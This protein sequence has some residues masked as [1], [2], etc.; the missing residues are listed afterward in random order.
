MIVFSYND[1]PFEQLTD[2]FAGFLQLAA[3]DRAAGHYDPKAVRQRL[4]LMGDAKVCVPM[5]VDLADRR[6][7][8]TDLNTGADGGFH[9]VRR[10]HAEV[11]G[12]CRDVLAHFAEGRRATLWDLA[13]AVAA[14]GSDEVLV[15]ERD[16]GGV[17]AWRR[18]GGEAVA[19]FAARLRDRRAPDAREGRPLTERL[20]G[21]RAFVALVDGDVPA[22]E[23]MSGTA[24]R[25]HPGPFDAAP[26][27]V[28][29]LTAGDLVARFGPGT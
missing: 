25:L 1:V 2:A 22:P 7:V 13:S 20:A 4:D 27:E 3:A 15:R 10:H 9:S 11:G 26:E 6:Y 29:R 17:Q 21:Q 18:G 16:G 23:T 24:Y 14:A 12:L 19:E 28:D 8:W 5:I